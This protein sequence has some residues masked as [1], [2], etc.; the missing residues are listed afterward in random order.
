MKDC[1][2]WL[3]PFDIDENMISWPWYAP[4]TTAKNN[5]HGAFRGVYP[6]TPRYVWLT[7]VS[8][9]KYL[10]LFPNIWSNLKILIVWLLEPRLLLKTST[11]SFPSLYPPQKAIWENLTN[12]TVKYEFETPN[13]FFHLPI[14]I[15]VKRLATGTFHDA[16][17]ILCK[18]N[19]FTPL[20]PAISPSL[21]RGKKSFTIAS[22][23]PSSRIAF[24]AG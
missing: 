5:T 17:C 23:G 16:H 20:L 12:M 6:P 3:Q 8:F 22:F 1:R 24:T 10:I 7:Q 11:D 15:P 21:L 4:V 2:F 19:F 13:K 14:V 18:Q 9:Q